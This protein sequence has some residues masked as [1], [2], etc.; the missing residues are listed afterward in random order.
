M[1]DAC[2]VIAAQ[3]EMMNRKEIAK[4]KFGFITLTSGVLYSSDR[5]AVIISDNGKVAVRVNDILLVKDLGEVEG[6]EIRLND[7]HQ[8]TL[9]VLETIEEIFGKFADVKGEKEDE[10][11]GQD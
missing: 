8:T 2:D 1:E 10:C 9:Y 7:T 11:T 3:K 5:Q 4:D 6:S